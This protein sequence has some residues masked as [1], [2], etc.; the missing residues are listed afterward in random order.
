MSPQLVLDNGEKIP[1]SGACLFYDS[2]GPQVWFYYDANKPFDRF[3]PPFAQTLLAQMSNGRT[4]WLLFNVP[5][6]SSR[7]IERLTLGRPGYEFY[8]EPPL[9][10]EGR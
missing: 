6:D 1:H 2:G 8:P 10:C 5:R 4:L 9:A 7:R 3:R